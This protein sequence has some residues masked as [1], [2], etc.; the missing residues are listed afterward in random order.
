MGTRVTTETETGHPLGRALRFSAKFFRH[1]RRIGSIAPSSPMM[2]RRLTRDVDGSR[3][4][5][6]LELGSGT[7][8][9]TAEAVRRMHGGSRMI[10]VE[11]DV[12]LAAM[13]RR[14]CPQAEVYC[15]DAVELEG[16]LDGLGVG[17]I[18]VLINCLPTPSLPAAVNRAIFEA[19]ARRM[20]RLRMT[21]LTEI[22][23]WYGRAYR[24]LFE[25]VRFFHVPLNIPPGGVYV[26]EG[27]RPG[28]AGNLCERR[29]F[30][31]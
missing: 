23:Y 11:A 25:E 17:R 21:Q 4:Q 19:A 20:R 3:A 31:R 24:R 12:E 15:A 7:G 8:C 30:R 27:L 16:L 5:V 6:I 18:D 2:G 28:Y 26:L 14:R 13:A 22:P 1:G 29:G 10:S 9:V